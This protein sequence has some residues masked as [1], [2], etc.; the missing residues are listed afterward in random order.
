[1]SI[2]FSFLLSISLSRHPSSSL[3]PY[4]SV[5]PSLPFSLSFALS[6]SFFKTRFGFFPFS[7]T[8]V[9]MMAVVM[10][11]ACSAATSLLLPLRLRLHPSPSPQNLWKQQVSSI[12]ICFVCPPS[13]PFFL[14]P[15][16]FSPLVNC[17]LSHLSSS[18]LA[19]S[20]TIPACSV[21]TMTMTM[22]SSP[23][24]QPQHRKRKQRQPL[25][26]QMRHSLGMMMTV[27]TVCLDRLLLLLLLNP[28]LLLLPR[29]CS[30]M[31]PTMM[32]AYLGEALG[33]GYEN[34][35]TRCITELVPL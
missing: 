19:M 29:L 23:P 12:H 30:V 32:V 7:A 1:M 28:S 8:G 4:P 34:S 15:H 20:K 13:L 6:S 22:T 26:Q 24:L 3:S 16:L 11:M 33:L 27:T 25:Q 14:P 31:T 17:T 2:P 21:T 9:A 35:K 5:Y 18:C 10:M